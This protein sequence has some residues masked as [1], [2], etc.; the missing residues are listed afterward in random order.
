MP[1]LDSQRLRESAEAHAPFALHRR[2][3]RVVRRGRGPG[4]R[5]VR[6]DV[7]ARETGLL[8]DGQRA[9][10]RRFVLAGKTDDDVR[11]EVEVVQ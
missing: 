5:R 11:G 1:I 8:D 3:N 2:R 10:E 4:A 7:N 6:K 9:P